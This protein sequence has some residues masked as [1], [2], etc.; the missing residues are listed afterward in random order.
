MSLSASFEKP[1]SR[2]APRGRGHVVPSGAT[3]G[4]RRRRRG[5]ARATEGCGT[6]RRSRVAVKKPER[7]WLSS[8]SG[9]TATARAAQPWLRAQAATRLGER[10]R[11]CRGR[12]RP[13]TTYSSPISASRTCSTLV[14]QLAV[15]MPTGSSAAPAREASR[16][17]PRGSS[18]SGGKAGV[19]PG[20]GGGEALFGKEAAQEV[21]CDLLRRAVGLP[22]RQMCVGHV[23]GAP[24]RCT[25]KLTSQRS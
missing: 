17:A 22:Y 15:A 3:P 5:A 6:R 2:G 11:R 14:L 12:A 19:P 1:S 20:R 4:R 21:A 7:P 24:S 18:S 9:P 16:T 13:A 23:R 8:P 25:T 10:R